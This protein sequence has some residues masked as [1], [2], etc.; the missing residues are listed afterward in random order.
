MCPVLEETWNCS[1]TVFVCVSLHHCRSV[2][3]HNFIDRWHRHP[4]G[5]LMEHRQTQLPSRQELP[6]ELSNRLWCG[7]QQDTDRWVG[8]RDRHPL[9]SKSNARQIWSKD[10]KFDCI[11]N[12]LTALSTELTDGGD[13]D[14]VGDEGFFSFM[15]TIQAWLSTV[16]TPALSGTS[17]PSPPK[18]QWWMLWRTF[19]T[20]EATPSQVA[21]TTQI[22][23]T[24]W[25][26]NENQNKS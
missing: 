17:M 14:D 19:P 5:R 11:P 10:P 20:K 6:G 12:I 2:C 21:L 1:V 7:H 13:D 23:A 3:V 26:M 9:I 25:R 8:S 22:V 24:I 4:G 16:E 18:T 15:C